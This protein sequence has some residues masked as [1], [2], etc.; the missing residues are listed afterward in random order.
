M[1][2]SEWHLCAYEDEIDEE[3]AYINDPNLFSIKIHHGG[4]FTNPPNREYKK[5]TFNYFDMVDVDLFS[6]I[7]LNDML[8]QLGYGKKDIMHYHYKILN[9]SL[10]YGLLALAS[11]VDVRSMIKYI[12]KLKRIEVYVQHGQGSDMGQG[13]D[14]DQVNDMEQGSDSD[15]EQG[16]KE[17][18]SEEDD[19]DE[20]DS[21][22]IDDE[23]HMMNEVEVDIKEYLENID[24]EWDD[25]KSRQEE[26]GISIL[27]NNLSLEIE[28]TIVINP[29]VPVRALQDQ[30][31]R[32]YQL[33]IFVS[34]IYRAKEKAT[35]KVKGDYRDQYALL[36]DY[37]LELQRTNHDTTV[38]IDIER[39]CDLA[40]PERQFKRIY[41]CIV[42]LKKGFKAG[43]K[44]LLGLDGC[45]M[46]G[47]F[48]GQLLSAIGVDLNH[49]TYPLTYALVKAE[50]I[51]SWTWFMT[52]LRDDLELSRKSNFTFI[53][54]R[55][56]IEI[57]AK[58]CKV[59]WNGRHQYGVTGPSGD[60]VVVDVHERTCS[61][62]KWELTGMHSFILDVSSTLLILLNNPSMIAINLGH[63]GRSSEPRKPQLAQRW[64]RRPGFVGVHEI[65][66][67]VGDP[68]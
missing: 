59:Q 35:L 68:H 6:V 25:D 9:N 53:S 28:E 31:K 56:K 29:D 17:D 21:D 10:N 12:G 33:N 15:E 47:S 8:C 13:N 50:T 2:V 44:D 62:R 60:Q 36:R 66:I 7:D 24:K 27:R 65:V 22:Y 57:K 38:K 63:M 19:S 48:P 23:D 5:G 20:E 49:G 41:V 26:W 11:D 42:A 18:D 34:K 64:K 55:Q 1:G 61:C 67:V 45:F 30:F 16:S 58:S 4:Y 52:C 3:L 46:K 32:K 14:I 37:A 43:L 39:C 40:V 54:D 51:S